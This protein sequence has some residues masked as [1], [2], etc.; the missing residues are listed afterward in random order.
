MMPRELDDF[1]DVA[2]PDRL[3]VLILSTANAPQRVLA[4]AC[5]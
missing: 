2:R 5:S 1:R 3:C 4:V